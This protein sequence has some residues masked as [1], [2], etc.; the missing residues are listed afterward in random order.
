MLRL[1]NRV[2]SVAPS[3]VEDYAD[4]SKYRFV[5]YSVKHYNDKVLIY[6][7]KE[8]FYVRVGPQSD[9]RKAFL[10]RKRQV[11]VGRIDTYNLL[12]S[13]QRTKVALYDYVVMNRFDYFCTFTFAED[14]EDIKLCKAKMQ[15]FLHKQKRKNGD[16]RYL[17]IPEFHE[18]HKAIHFHALISGFLAKDLY[19][20]HKKDGSPAISKRGQHYLGHHDYDCKDTNPDQH[21]GWS[22]IER[23]SG[24]EESYPILGNYIRKYITKDMP[25][26]P[27]KKRYWVSQNL[28]KPVSESFE[29]LDI[30]D[31]ESAVIVLD[32][33]IVK[34]YE[35]PKEN[36]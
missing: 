10:R 15:T 23:I 3:K 25:L 24:G 34:I 21:I 30:T 11:N 28:Q 6:E 1:T 4:E 31:L 12:R 18:D 19:P 7:F 17:I 5:K 2:P 33:D 13:I 36:T 8:G 16:F 14:R 22:T 29:Y 20:K 26:F 9:E 35:L 32:N 27:G